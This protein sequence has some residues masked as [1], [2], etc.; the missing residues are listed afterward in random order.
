M[1]PHCGSFQNRAQGWYVRLSI[2]G[3][4]VCRF[5]KDYRLAEQV[6]YELKKKQELLKLSKKLKGFDD[7]LSSLL[8]IDESEKGKFVKLKVFWSK[9]Y[10]WLINH[11]KQSTVTER[12]SKWKKT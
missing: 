7:N 8:G 3:V 12:V 6:Y 4:V 2:D 11:K 1:C 10:S 9:Y 5:F